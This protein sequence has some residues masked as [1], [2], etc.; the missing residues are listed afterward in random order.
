[1]KQR[2]RRRQPFIRVEI[3]PRLP[4]T[5]GLRSKQGTIPYSLLESVLHSRL[6]LILPG[7][8]TNLHILVMGSGGRMA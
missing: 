2:L 1:M 3:S 5:L 7:I 4:G 6:W 8:K